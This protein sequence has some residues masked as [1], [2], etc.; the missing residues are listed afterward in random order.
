MGATTMPETKVAEQQRLEIRRVIR[1]SRARVFAAWTQPEQMRQWFGREIDQVESIGLDVRMGGVY[2]I[3]MAGSCGT[4]GDGAKSEVSGGYIEVIPNE[5]VQF[6]WRPLWNPAEESLVTVQLR[7]VEGG[8]ELV[9]THERF[10]SMES[11]NAHLQGWTSSMNKL[12][13]MLQS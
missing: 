9:L 12:E 3:R 5:K 10:A 8:T 2:H 4:A 7:D 13:R 11:R 1:A 6:T